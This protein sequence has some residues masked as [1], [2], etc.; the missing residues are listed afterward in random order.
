MPGPVAALAPLLLV[1]APGPAGVRSPAGEWES[2]IGRI[3]IRAQAGG[4]RGTLVAPSSA[5]R[6]EVGEEVFRAS[7]LDD[8]LAG[9]LRLCTEGAACGEAGWSAA[10]LL[11]GNDRLAGAVHVAPGCEAP[12]GKG[13][14]LTLARVASDGA[15]AGRPSAPR[16][17]KPAAAEPTTASPSD[18]GAGGATTGPEPYTPAA[19]AEQARTLLREA[20]G[21]LAAGSFEA[22]RGRYLAALEVEPGLAEAYN[23]VGVTYRMRNELGEA[24]TWY[25]RALAAAPG[26]G[27]AYYNI[28]CVYALQGRSALALRY[29]RVA[30]LEGHAT[31][32]AID[33]DPDL[34]SLR[35]EPG[36]R[37][38]VKAPR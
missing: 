28:A 20:G 36:Y 17:G 19:T 34:E 13:G 2:P 4:Y 35:D 6:L 8:S 22:A 32:E 37:A 5:C 7:L 31:A 24:L 23:G 9:E 27:D 33:A 12:V 1:L 25:K 3:R 11:V 10:M 16:A 18:A 38:L 26:F 30:A 29:L 15:R 14:A 21:F